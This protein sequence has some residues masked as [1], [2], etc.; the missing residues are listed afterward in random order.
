MPLLR[1]RGAS[2][3]GLSVREMRDVHL[4]HLQLPGRH[5]VPEVL[6]GD[7]FR[8]ARHP[9]SRDSA[10]RLARALSSRYIRARSPIAPVLHEPRAA[11][12]QETQIL[13]GHTSEVVESDGKW[14]KVRGADGYEGWMHEGFSEPAEGAGLDEWGW[15]SEGWLSMGCGIRNAHGMTIDLPLGALIRSGPCVSGRSMELARR[16]E[17][18]PPEP[19]AIVASATGLFQGTYY[20]WGGITPWGADCSGMVQTV[21]ALHGIKL[22]RDA[23]QQ[24]TQGVPV[25]GGIENIV[26][27]D[28]LFFSDREDG[29]TT[30]VA[31]ATTS[32]SIVHLAL[33]RGGHCVES[34]ERPD[35]YVRALLANFR[36]ARR[37]L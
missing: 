25:E 24:A 16:R 23:W 10:H 4:R 28:L 34:L 1:E 32:H 33:G 21:F 27:A 12:S 22:P 31:M 13:Y 7:A 35:E 30:H 36:F 20:Q 37:I 19:D 15:S 9:G 5:D 17:V 18:F 14:L 26:P 8:S 6:G 11:A 2:V 29:R 3:G